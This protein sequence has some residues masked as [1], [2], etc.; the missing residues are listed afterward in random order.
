MT[1]LGKSIKQFEDAAGI[2]KE[3]ATT[4]GRSE[5]MGEEAVT[6]KTKNT[7]WAGQKTMVARIT[8][9]TVQLVLGFSLILHLGKELTVQSRLGGER[10]DISTNHERR[11]EQ[12][13]DGPTGSFS[14]GKEW[15]VMPKGSPLPGLY[16]TAKE[17]SHYAHGC[18]EGKA[19]YPICGPKG[20][21]ITSLFT[22]QRDA[23]C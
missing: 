22:L 23:P 19:R 7:L 5:S 21:N 17:E 8:K 12:E 1:S 4:T 14:V 18:P 16:T 6:G 2:V 20:V 3:A 11:T 15:E 13:R 10:V 9:R